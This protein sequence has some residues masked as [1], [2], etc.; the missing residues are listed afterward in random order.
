MD[1]T[2]ELMLD[3]GNMTL[4]LIKDSFKCNKDALSVFIEKMNDFEGIASSNTV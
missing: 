3:P 2:F 4:F 1:I